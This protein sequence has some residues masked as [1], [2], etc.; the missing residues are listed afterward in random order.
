MYAWSRFQKSVNEWGRVEEW[1]EPG[2]EISQSDLG[3]ND[4]EW[5]SLIDSGAVREEE[6][7]DIDRQTT[8]ADYYKANPDEAPEVNV[9]ETTPSE[10]AMP[11]T[12][13][14]DETGKKLP[15]AK[16]AQEAANDEGQKEPWK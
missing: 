1:I 10:I 6:Y 5:Q 12:E 2:D 11:K 3:V 15:G 4:E 7:P 16:A 9:D 13:T 8:P 14:A